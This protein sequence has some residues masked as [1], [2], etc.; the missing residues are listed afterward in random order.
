MNN[1]IT[2]LPAG[3]S[4][5]LLPEDYGWSSF[6]THKEYGF[7]WRKVLVFFLQMALVALAGWLLFFT[8]MLNLPEGNSIRKALVFAWILV[9]MISYEVKLLYI[10]RQFRLF[11]IFFVLPVLFSALIVYMVIFTRKND[12]PIGI[13]DFLAGPFVLFG[14]FLNTWPEIMRMHWKAHSQNKGKLTLRVILNLDSL[15]N[16]LQA[17]R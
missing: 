2:K 17:D 7:T 11:E 13:V 10:E 15:L 6:R 12:N 4:S 3:E 14:T 8:T 1:A 16:L 5:A 9:V